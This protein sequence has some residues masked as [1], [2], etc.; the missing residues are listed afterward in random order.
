MVSAMTQVL[1]TTALVSV[2]D[3]YALVGEETCIKWEKLGDMDSKIHWQYGAEADAIISEGVPPMLAYKAIAKKAGKKA[4]TV[5]QAYY[6]YK[7]FTLEQR[8]E[9][10]LCP[11]S[12]FRHAKNTVAPLEVLQHYIDKL[13]MVDEVEEIFPA[14]TG[15]DE[16]E[17][18]FIQTGF[19]RMFYLI[20]REI[21]GMEAKVKNKVVR[22]LKIIDRIIT[23]VNK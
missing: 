19:P 12:V 16:V 14:T 9:F 20:Y 4:E 23:E 1:N 6:T 3:V 22:I 10:E 2:S 17:T 11:Y 7:A 8:K 21:W 5:R 13:C 15:S 18:G